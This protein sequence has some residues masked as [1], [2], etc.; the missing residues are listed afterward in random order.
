MESN[1][2]KKI[3]IHA[4]KTFCKEALSYFETKE[5]ISRGQ[6]IIH[7]FALNF[8]CFDKLD[9][10]YDVILV[11]KDG[12]IQLSDMLQNKGQGYSLGKEIRRAHNMQKMFVANALQFKP[13]PQGA[14]FI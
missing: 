13:H 7:T 12:Y 14:D 2:T 5:A 8:F 3:I 4:D 1:L 11:A 6:E 10:G 9:Q